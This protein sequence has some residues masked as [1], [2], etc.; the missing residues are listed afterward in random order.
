MKRLLAPYYK[1]EPEMIHIP[2]GE[3]LMGSDPVQDPHAREEE[4][5]QHPVYLP[6]YAMAKTAVTNAQYAVFLCATHHAPPQHWRWLR[7]SHRWAPPRRRHY[8]AV[9]VTWYD[10]RAYCQWL[11]EITGKLYRLPTEAEWEKAARGAEGQIYPWGNAWDANR[12]NIQGEA[13][14]KDTRPVHAHP[15]GASPYGLL[16]MVG[17]I[18]E[19]TSSL[20]GIEL[21]PPTYTYPYDP[22]DGRE[23]PIANHYIRR[24]LRGVSF[25]NRCPMAR[26][27]ARYRYSPRN[28]F[29]SVGFRVALSLV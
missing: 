24:V 11:R 21:D 26:C 15:Q 23:N 2:A 12:C 18:W 27:A 13:E 3:F 6:D 9:Y 22:L 10:A 1:F 8:P 14:A 25:Y 29:D 5:P 17:N 19:W 16:D 28:R 20:W 4:Q 7:W